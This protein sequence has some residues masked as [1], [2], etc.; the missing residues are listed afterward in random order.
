MDAAYDQQAVKSYLKPLI[1]KKNLG[2][3]HNF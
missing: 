2:K 3:L 1:R